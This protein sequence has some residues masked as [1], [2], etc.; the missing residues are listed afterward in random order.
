VV[1]FGLP[2]A[3]WRG[4]GAWRAAEPGDAA[5]QGTSAAR[6]RDEEPGGNA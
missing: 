1:K 4:Q 2:V 6:Q 5:P 3:G